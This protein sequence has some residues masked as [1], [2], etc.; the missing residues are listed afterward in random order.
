MEQYWI[1]KT[2][3]TS[4]ALGHLRGY[5]I[6][7]LLYNDTITPS[8]FKFIFKT[9]QHSYE[10]AGDVMDEFS[11]NRIKKRAEEFGIIL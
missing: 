11:T 9:L 3:S 4:T 2:M 1:D 8:R 7:E 5:M 10:L 6:G